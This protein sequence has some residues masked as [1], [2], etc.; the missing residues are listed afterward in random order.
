MKETE[1]KENIYRFLVENEKGATASNIAE[2]IGSNRMTITKYLNMMKGQDLVDYRGIG[3]A[4]L[5]FINHSPILNSFDKG[6][7]VPI[8]EAM[9]LLGEG[10]CIIDRDMRI[11][12]YNDVVGRLVGKL[13]DNKGK[14][15][16]DLC[17]IKP[18]DKNQHCVVKTL[19]TGETHKA[20]QQLTAK[21]GKK[22]YFEVVSSPIKDK[23]NRV[24]AAIVLLIDLNDY[25][26]KMQ[27][28]KA[29]LVK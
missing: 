24:I 6:Y 3:M 12:W 17:D 4:K 20:V 18:G 22:L 27:E 2:A 21:N 10:I 16:Y 19:S 11:L 26:R 13:E 1:F 25:E 23:K 29:L 14:L 15:C 5:W 7:N 28:L 8:K 9:N